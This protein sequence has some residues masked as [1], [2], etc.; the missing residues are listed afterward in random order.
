VRHTLRYLMTNPEEVK[1]LIRHN[2]W[3]EDALLRVAH[4]L[5]ATIN[6]PARAARE[7][8]HVFG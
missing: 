1:R 3:A 5:R 6:P 7:L 2:P 8:P 4:D